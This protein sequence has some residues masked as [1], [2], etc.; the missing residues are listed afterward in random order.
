MFKLVSTAFNQGE[1]LTTCGGLNCD[2]CFILQRVSQILNWLVLIAGVITVIFLVVKILARSKEENTKLKKIFRAV[3]V[4][5]FSLLA[6]W[7][8]THLIFKTKGASYKNYWWSLNC[9]VENPITIPS[10]LPAKKPADLLKAVENGGELGALIPRDTTKEELLELIQN[11]PEG[12]ALIFKENKRKSGEDP[13]A[14]VKKENGKIKIVD[15][16]KGSSFNPLPFHLSINKAKAA[17]IADIGFGDGGLIDLINFIIGLIQQNIQL[18]M[19]LMETGSQW[20]NVDVCMSSGGIWYRFNN[21]CDLEQSMCSADDSLEDCTSDSSSTPADGCLCPIGSCLQNGQCVSSNS[22]P[23]PIPTPTPTPSTTSCP[24]PSQTLPSLAELQQGC[25]YAGGTLQFA[26]GTYF[27][28]CSPDSLISVDACGIAKCLPSTIGSN[29]SKSGGQW[30]GESSSDGSISGSL[31]CTDDSEALYYLNNSNDWVCTTAGGMPLCQGKPAS[32]SFAC[33]CPDGQCVDRD[34]AI[35]RSTQQPVF[36]SNPSVYAKRNCQLSGGTW[37]NLGGCCGVERQV[38]GQQMLA[39]DCPI[40][41][42]MYQEGCICPENNCLSEI[43]GQCVNKSG[44]IVIENSDQKRCQDSGGIWAYLL[45]AGPYCKCP[46]DDQPKSGQKVCSSTTVTNYGQKNC[47]DSGGTWKQMP[48]LCGRGA[49]LC[50]G[51]FVASGCVSDY[52]PYGCSCPEGTCL[53]AVGGRCVNNLG[54]TEE[55]RRQNC[56][57]SGGSWKQFSNQCV[58]DYSQRCIYKGSVMNCSYSNAPFWGCEC[59]SEKLVYRYPTGKKI[60]DY[61]PSDEEGSC[62]E[63][64]MCLDE[65]GRCTSL[66]TS[67]TPN[68]GQKTCESSGGTWTADG[69]GNCKCPAGMLTRRTGGETQCYSAATLQ[70]TCTASGGE[71]KKLTGLGMAGPV[72]EEANAKDC[73]NLSTSVQYDQS[74]GPMSCP[75]GAI[76]DPAGISYYCDCKTNQCVDL[77]SGSPRCTD[78]SGTGDGCFDT[79][80]PCGRICPEEKVI[81]ES[82]FSSADTQMIVTNI[83]KFTQLKIRTIRKISDTQAE[84]MVGGCAGEAYKAT[85]VTAG[86]AVTWQIEH[87]GNWES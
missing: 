85:R 6:V 18:T 42:K 54:T 80:A 17:S 7:F 70:S 55:E 87:G 75:A 86:S 20:D 59:P 76:C 69:G 66:F 62:K 23:T 29:C 79:G 56:A 46:G 41:A 38:C 73:Q 37:D 65:T 4:T 48:E 27:C 19:T 83:R 67:P 33:K 32:A 72:P 36:P 82:P 44:T 31:S 12:T 25:G 61:C 16:K 63:E 58:A 5:F 77:S 28:T 74:M 14:T 3:A 34:T 30:L 57:V 81:K 78:N 11:L 13:I 15:F 22:A 40:G 9:A 49:A 45:D 64:S 43:G 35:C 84:V 68:P 8:L 21:Q 24:N 53:A 26:Y 39:C 52:S 1:G 60:F 51:K 47:Q 2:T 10:H 50:G 71:W